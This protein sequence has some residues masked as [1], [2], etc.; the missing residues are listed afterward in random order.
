MKN[1]V[2][3]PPHIHPKNVRNE[4]DSR[5]NILADAKLFGCYEEI[6]RCFARYD[7]MLANCK[8]EIERKD[9]AVLGSAEIYRIM[10]L[11]GGLSVDGK[12][13][14]PSDEEIKEET[15]NKA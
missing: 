8:N 1:K 14:I 9:I 7:R 4:V 12:N 5:K 10:G 2:K 6:V 3:I 15:K 11:K 13:I